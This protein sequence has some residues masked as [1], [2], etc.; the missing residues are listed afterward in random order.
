MRNRIQ[1]LKIDAKTWC[2]DANSLRYVA[3]TYFENLFAECS[4]SLDPFPIT[5]LFLAL[6]KGDL[7][8]LNAILTDDDIK[9]ALFS[10]A[11]LK[12]QGIDGI[13]V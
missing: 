9:D 2:D 7:N 8:H 10:M 4:P 12:A 6:S 11:P 13:H 1:T 3:T 5:G